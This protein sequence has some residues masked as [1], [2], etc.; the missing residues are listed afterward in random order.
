MRAAGRWSLRFGFETSSSR[1]EAKTDALQLRR[2]NEIFDRLGF[3]KDDVRIYLLAGL[4]HQK[5]S[6]VADSIAF[7]KDLGLRPVPNEYSPVP[8]SSLFGEA[9]RSSAY[10][11]KGEPLYHNKTIVPCGWEGLTYDDMQDL[12][13]LAR[14]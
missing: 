10:D 13:S 9:D 5:A 1:L 6:E 2:V 7:V 8:G 4:P 11:L 12:K 3:E 14:L